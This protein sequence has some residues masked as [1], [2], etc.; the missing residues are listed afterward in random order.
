MPRSPRESA[1]GLHPLSRGQQLRAHAYHLLE[2]WFFRTCLPGLLIQKKY[3]AFQRLRQGDRSA[4]ELISRLEEI[5]QRNLPCD[6]EHIKHLCRLLDQEVGNLV[7][8]LAAFNPL[9]YALL[10]NYHRKYAFYVR[11]ALMEEE[12]ST[13]PPY[14]LTLDAPRQEDRVG[15]KGATLS[16]L[17]STHGL[18][19]PQGF[20][21]T[22]RAFHLFIRQNRLEGMIREQLSRLGPDGF[23]DIE[24]ISREVRREIMTGDIPGELNEE[25][26]N[27]LKTLGLEDAAL[28]VRSSAVAEDVQASFAGQYQSLLNVQ[29][30]DWQEAYKRV[31]ASKYSP[32]ALTYRIGQGMSDR[33]TPMAVLVMPVIQSK[34]SGILYTRGQEKASEASL[35]MVSGF[36]EDLAAGAGFEARATFDTQTHELELLNPAGL[37]D[38]SIVQDLFALGQDLDRL[39]G[40]G[41]DVEWVVDHA[42][43]IH[44]VQSRPL[45]TSRTVTSELPD[46]DPAEVLCTGQWVSSGRASG[47]VFRLGPAQSPASVP[48]GSILVTD[49]LPPELTLALPRTSAIV[50]L[51]GSP[52]CHLASVAREAGV[53]VICNAPSARNLLPDQWISVDG[54]QGLVLDGQR[55]P[56]GQPETQGQ[57]PHVQ[58]PVRTMLEQALTSISPL[59]LRD[60]NS[61]EFS[62]QACQS[63]HDIVRFVHES[64]VREMFSLVGRRGLNTYG[65]KRLLSHLPLVMHVLDVSQGLA[66]EAAASKTVTE[67]Q[68]LSEPMKH[69]FA[70]LSSPVVDWD[71][72]ILHYDWDAFSK[73]SASFVN[74][75][76]S[77][78][79][80][81][82]AILASDYLH[83]LLRFG[84]HFAVVD[85]VLRTEAEQ[86]YIHFSFKGGGGDDEQ[87]S[88]RVELIKLILEHFLFSV[89]IASDLLEASFDRRGPAESAAALHVLGIVLGKTVLLDMRLKD[90]AHVVELSTSIISQIH[91]LLPVQENQ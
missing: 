80:S 41:Q 7:A 77:T 14:V 43:R 10:H 28:A 13:E 89:T 63:L 36:G 49:E 2:N 74:V 64:G 58:S 12:A 55:F 60:P 47:L 16:T 42:D 61:D 4:L 45:R 27:S 51:K 57:Q 72:A 66:S 85:T 3:R 75:E 68:L 15:G 31:I 69:L 81:S 11:L 83:A 76:K 62:I 34:V 79:F 17:L 21:I 50:A 82:Y 87:R 52:A 39:F 18:H 33:M 6:V 37:L 5:Q 29:P 90:E 91:D 19:V 88:Y 71:P 40:Q 20:A 53:P 1:H 44:I 24:D 67:E 56:P 22:T 46:Y 9:R 84:Y 86:N 65:A 54:D 38:D 70:G 48:A 8:S 25:V 73:S 59:S 78:L 35:Y 32:H 26:R 23:E 30:G